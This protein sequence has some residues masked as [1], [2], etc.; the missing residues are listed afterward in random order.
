MVAGRNGQTDERALAEC[1]RQW[2][3][4]HHGVGP[5]QR[6]LAGAGGL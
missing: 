5:A 3:I 1:I 2:L 4:A 6:Q